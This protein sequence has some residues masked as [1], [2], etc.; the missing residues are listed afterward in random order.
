VLTLTATPIQGFDS[1]YESDLN[2]VMHRAPSLVRVVSTMAVAI[3]YHLEQPLARVVE[4]CLAEE[5]LCGM[6]FFF[7]FL[8]SSF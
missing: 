2:P 8:F 1:G 4:H 6:V 3:D 5:G 7:F